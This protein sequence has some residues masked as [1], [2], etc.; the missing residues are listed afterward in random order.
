[1]PELK[2]TIIRLGGKAF[3][4]YL[5]AAQR[6]SKLWWVQFEEGN[7]NTSVTLKFT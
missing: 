4:L 5:G 7:K 2:R 6:T 1:M 3:F